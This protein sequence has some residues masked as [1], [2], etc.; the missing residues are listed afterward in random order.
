VKPSTIRT[1]PVS[2]R[3]GIA[4]SALCLVHCLL[5]P[6][7]VTA[8]PA[9]LLASLF[10]WAHDSTV[11]HT[12]LLGVVLLI[13]GPVLSQGGRHDRRIWPMAVV[14]F[15]FLGATLFVEPESLEQLAT[16]IGATLL[17]GAHVLNLARRNR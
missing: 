7:L 2:D 17:V 3:L 11:F 9:F 5:L 1:A 8:F 10:D 6:V 12:V 15:L 14:G 13:S 4:L 16:V